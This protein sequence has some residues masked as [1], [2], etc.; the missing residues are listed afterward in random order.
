MGGGAGRWPG[1]GTTG[2]AGPVAP[3]G[4]AVKAKYFS[5][6]M[7]VCL[8]RSLPWIMAWRKGRAKAA[9]AALSTI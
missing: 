2:P 4:P 7:A 1:A 5:I 6:M 9:R 8:G 3:T